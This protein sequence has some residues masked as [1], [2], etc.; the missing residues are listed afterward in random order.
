METDTDSTPALRRGLDGYVRAV[1]R[2]LD[3]PAESTSFEISD[4]A[5]AYIG[6]STRWPSLPGNDLMLIWDERTGWSLAVETT[7]AE[8]GIVI[9]ELPRDVVPAPSVVSRWVA[10]TLSGHDETVPR[11][12][13]ATAVDRHALADRLAVYTSG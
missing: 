1:A 4:T 5:T 9:A 7:P 3:I 12:R 13:S 2:E 11:Q 8:R 6:L 10:E